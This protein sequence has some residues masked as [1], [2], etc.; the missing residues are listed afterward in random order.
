M[1]SIKE[2]IQVGTGITSILMIFIILCLTAF[3]VLSFSTAKMDLRL[4][5]KS[6][7]NTKDYYLIEGKAYK[8]LSNI[9]AVL[10]KY[11]KSDISNEEVFDKFKKDLKGLSDYLEV[12]NKDNQITCIYIIPE[13]DNKELR[14][15]ITFEKENDVLSYSINQLA[16]K[17]N[18]DPFGEVLE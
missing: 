8:M 6:I 10:Y 17:I 5:N 3:G 12:Y 15:K 13:S 9:D 18:E 14:L 1:K 4:T 16:L 11:N 7:D 2:R